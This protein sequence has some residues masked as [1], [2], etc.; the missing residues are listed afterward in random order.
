MTGASTPV[1]FVNGTISTME[2][3]HRPAAAAVIDGDRIVARFTREPASTD[4]E[5]GRCDLRWAGRSSPDGLG[6]RDHHRLASHRDRRALLRHA[7]V[8]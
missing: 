6:M 5:S 3:G 1:V 2:P 7:Q 4:A 8:R